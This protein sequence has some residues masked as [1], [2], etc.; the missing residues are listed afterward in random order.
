MVEHEVNPYKAQKPQMFLN[1]N[2]IIDQ[3][4]HEVNFVESAITGKYSHRM[5]RSKNPST[6]YSDIVAEQL[7]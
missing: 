6:I 2:K 1:I 4:K 7:S 5:I 3:R